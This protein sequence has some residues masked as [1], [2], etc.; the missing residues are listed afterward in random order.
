[1]PKKA[2]TLVEVVLVILAIGI[3]A[4]IIVPRFGGKDF[5]DLLKL[6]GVAHQLASDI[7]FARQLAVTH[8]KAYTIEITTGEGG[9]QTYDIYEGTPSAKGASL[10]KDFPKA[11]PD[12]FTLSGAEYFTFRR[13]GNADSGGTITLGSVTSDNA[14]H[15]YD[16][17]VEALTGSVITEERIVQE[18]E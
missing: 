4:A 8:S 18:I 7:R 15:S 3:L 17:I 2:F 14:V 13:L 16:I 1:M 6:R 10:E 9:N 5:F 11:I 12:D